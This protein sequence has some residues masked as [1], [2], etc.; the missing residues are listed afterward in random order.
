MR[1]RFTL[2]SAGPLLGVA[3]FLAAGLC[4]TDASKPSE[5]KARP[6][7]PLTDEVTAPA[8]ALG[9]AYAAVARAV[10]PAVVSVSSEKMLNLR[11]QEM[12]S[13]FG[14]DF[15]RHFFGDQ[16]EMPAPEPRERK[17]YRIPQRGLGTGI[18]IDR[19]GH[20]LTNFHVVADVDEIKIIL[21]DQRGFAAKIVGSDAKTD[22]AVIQL[23]GKAPADL[24]T[25]QL[26]DSDTPEVGDPVLAIGAP[27]GLTQ[28]VTAGIISA[29]GRSNVGIADFED[30]LQ[31]DAAINPGNSGGPLVNMRGEVIGLNTA[32]ATKVGQYSGVGF[33]IPSNMI[34]A[35][36]P[37]LIKGGTITRGM[38]GVIIQNLTPDLA[39]RFHVPE[40]TEGEAHGVLVSQVNPGSPA[41]KAGIKPGDVILSYRGK[42]VQDMGEFRNLVAAT[43]PGTKVD[44]DVFRDGKKVAVHTT[45]GQL[46]SGPVASEHGGES[47]NVARFGF[48]VEPLTPA[49]AK[50]LNVEHEHGVVIVHVEQ[51]SVAALAGL[52]PNDLIVEA[53][54]QKVTSVADLENAL[55]KNQEGLLLLIKRHGASLFVILNKG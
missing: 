23:K 25:A 41:D 17:E 2:G 34:K 27:F 40:P 51:G 19:A 52:Q 43:A 30:F 53:D 3:G 21:P 39:K 49:L 54:R 15:F 28:T 24:S 7:P 35:E 10:N 33:S 6:A 4:M 1:L 16:F 47:G 14:G 29:K 5:P 48:T 37:V 12:P 22:I 55:A 46:P 8:R 9:A 31:T 26:G 38:I 44:L 42:T 45:V 50:R 32:I 11:S 20:V 13:P 36:L 18:I